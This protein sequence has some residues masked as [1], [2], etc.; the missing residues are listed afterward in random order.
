MKS[1]NFCK[2]ISFTRLNYYKKGLMFVMQYLC[3]RIEYRNEF[4][5]LADPGPCYS[6]T[7][8]NVH[9]GCPNRL[10]GARRKA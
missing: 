1:V 4:I 6:P 9:M 10:M 5:R 3:A 2:L 8:K 7:V